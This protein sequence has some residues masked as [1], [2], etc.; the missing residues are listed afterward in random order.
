MQVGIHYGGV[1][2]EFV[3]WNGVVKWEI[4]Q[5]GH[6]FISAENGTH[7][8]CVHLQEKFIFLCASAILLLFFKILLARYLLGIMYLKCT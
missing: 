5:W 7:M 1:F 8:V 4:A 2:Y 3:P 6:W